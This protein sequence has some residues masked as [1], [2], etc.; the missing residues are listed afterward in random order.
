V[1]RAFGVLAALLFA[2]AT[3]AAPQF[4]PA[5]EVAP[6][7]ADVGSG[8]ELTMGD[9]NGDGI[10]DAVI[11]RITY[12]P[13]HIT[14]PIGIYLGNGK[15]GYTDGSSLWVGPAARTEWG[16]QILIADFNGDGRNDIFV[17]DHGYDA[18]PYPG[19]PNTLVL[20]TPQGTLVDASGNLPAESDFSH[21][22]TAA[23]IDGDGDLDIYVGN[24]PAGPGTGPPEIL[25]NDGTGHFTRHTD[26]LPPEVLDDAARS[27][28]RSLF[29]D[30]GDGSPDLVL[31]DDSRND[32][33]RVLLNDGTGH[34]SY[35]NALPAKP[36]GPGAIAISLATLDINRDR[37]PDLLVGYTQSDPYY[38]GSMVQVL[39]NNG[40]GTFTDGTA[41]WLPDQPTTQGWPYAFRIA[42]V[43]RD[44]RPDLGVV[45]NGNG[46][47]GLLYVADRQGVLRQVPFQPAT[48]F[49]AL[50]DANSD[51]YPDVFSVQP[52]APHPERHFVQLQISPPAVSVSGFAPSSG[53]VGTTVTVRGFNLDAATT[54]SL[55]GRRVAFTSVSSSV[56]TFVVPAGSVTGH[57]GVL[58]PRGV[59]LSSGVFTVTP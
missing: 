44:L 54:V 43:N 37:H 32:V 3:V 48:P 15:G 40:D 53:R 38:V 35:G 6:S 26:L 7:E 31:G 19:H 11:T 52:Y 27:Y 41:Q 25:L 10:A 47:L 8:T 13:A 14:H 30:N 42:D 2:T 5:K 24:L 59:A 49:F 23:D 18:D 36:F 56:L 4:G 45:L 58:T 29:V 17:A 55:G 28:T 16:R 22:A 51:G 57:I 50:V 39:V 34:F 1:V 21:S 46:E 12:P 33:S 9:V 20:S